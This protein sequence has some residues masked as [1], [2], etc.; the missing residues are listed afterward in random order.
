MDIPALES[1]LT[2]L[3]GAGV[4]EPRVF[5][6][7]T[8]DLSPEALKAAREHNKELLFAH[9]KAM[10]DY[11]K[12]TGE[13][14]FNIA[15]MDLTDLSEYSMENIKEVPFFNMGV[16][17]V[18]QKGVDVV[19]GAW[20]DVLNRWDDLFPGKPR[21]I[22]NIGGFDPEAHKPYF[23]MVKAGKE[24]LGDKGKSIVHWDGFVPNNILMAG[25]DWTMRPS[26]FEPDG[27]KWESLY[28]GT[29]VIMSR[30]GG[31]IDSVQDGVNGFLTSRTVPEIEEYVRNLGLIGDDYEKAVLQEKIKDFA[32]VIIKA[33]DAFYDGNTQDAMVLNA[34]N[35]NQSWVIKDKDGK[36]ISCPSLEH[37][38]D[39]GFD[40]SK[41]PAVAE[42]AYNKQ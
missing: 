11:N 33:L 30:V 21:P 6:V 5:A 32:E 16:R 17:F 15:E 22:V 41:F 10:I 20:V 37:L 9:V 1:K 34:I 28:K 18:Q 4:L 14:V 12:A 40:L 13:N 7:A 26:H 36:I 3:K 38:R 27:D 39:L 8:N 24:K 19:I 23:N 31:H 42:S 25:S 2:E 35:G 29:P